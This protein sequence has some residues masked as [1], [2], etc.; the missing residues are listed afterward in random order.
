M[1]G[2]IQGDSRTFRLGAFSGWITVNADD[3]DPAE[4]LANAE[5]DPAIGGRTVVRHAQIMAGSTVN[6]TPMS[7][8]AAHTLSSWERTSAMPGT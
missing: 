1:Q 2:L 7:E 5:G 3:M 4:E 8:P 6:A